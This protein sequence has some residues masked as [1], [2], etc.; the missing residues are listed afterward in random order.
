M[1]VSPKQYAESLFE[2]IK[3]G[4]ENETFIANIFTDFST[5]E[6]VYI[7]NSYS[8][9]KAIKMA[10]AEY[11]EK[12]TDIV[13]SIEFL[14]KTT[15]KGKPFNQFDIGYCTTAEYEAAQ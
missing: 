9:N 5:G 13:F 6:D 10:R 12:L 15:V 1:K 11:V 2:S 4:K 8:I 14:G 3:E 7:G